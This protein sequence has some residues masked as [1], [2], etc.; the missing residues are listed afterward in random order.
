[1]PGIP[2]PRISRFWVPSNLLSLPVFLFGLLIVVAMNFTDSFNNPSG[3]YLLRLVIVSLCQ[4]CVW[5]MLWV[6]DHTI[7]SVITANWKPVA[8]ISLLIVLALARGLALAGAFQ[9]LGIAPASIQNRLVSSVSIFLIFGM[10]MSTA[11]GAAREHDLIGNALIEDRERLQALRGEASSQ[12]QQQTEALLDGVRKQISQALWPVS[13]GD[14]DTTLATLQFAI[15]E[16]VRPL[17]R[18]LSDETSPRLSDT[19]PVRA[20]RPRIDWR[21]G[22]MNALDM[23]AARPMVFGAL[24]AIGSVPYCAQVMPFWQALILSFLMGLVPAMVLWMLRSLARWLPAPLRRYGLIPSLVVSTLCGTLL[25]IPVAQP[26]YVTLRIW[27]FVSLSTLIGYVI[28]AA[29][30]A[31]DRAEQQ[32]RAAER[33]NADLRWAIGRRRAE[34]YLRRS[35][36][37]RALHG[38][39]QAALT[40]AYL[41]L[42]VAVKSGQG[43][44]A[45]LAEAQIDAERATSFTMS[46][47]EESLPVETV[48]ETAAQTWAG[49]A[50]V[51]SSL[52]EDDIARTNS[53][54]VCLGVL[55]ELIPELCFN[56]IKHSHA[57]NISVSANWPDERTLEITVQ[58]DG[59]EYR[60]S[61]QLSGLGSHML[62]ETA[63]HWNRTGSEHGTT[64]AVQLAFAGGA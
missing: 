5:A 57:Q 2:M 40:A 25:F 26:G 54:A 18:R 4:L 20:I 12:E 24:L 31:F 48:I 58:S 37:A 34:N 51:N 59:D 38:H 45:A 21:A 63:M 9:A 1:M 7:F 3:N 39:V 14:S 49:L 42:S 16:V 32:R 10:L 13:I 6:T 46:Q 44:E 55:T 17:S 27:Q 15:N 56:A 11:I 19:V 23:N 28:A 33:E 52:S 53:D 41:R 61:D 36:V 60:P 35:A 64:V 8:F 62:N 29:L 43:V 47:F 30:L 22:A 50:A